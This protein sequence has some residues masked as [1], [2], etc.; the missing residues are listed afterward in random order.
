M[1]HL[2]RSRA[3]IALI[4]ALV[5]AW[6]SVGG[7]LAQTPG[8]G[9]PD[10]TTVGCSSGRAPSRGPRKISHRKAAAPAA[11]IAPKTS[12]TIA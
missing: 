10:R 7:A 5:L 3:L 4:S 12:E 6:G 2:P 1:S 8:L 9:S 11:K